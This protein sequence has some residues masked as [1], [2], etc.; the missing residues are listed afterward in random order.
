MV[1]TI[2]AQYA[3]TG[4][5]AGQKGFAASRPSVKPTVWPFAA[6]SASTA[7]S[8]LPPPRPLFAIRLAVVI[9]SNTTSVSPI[10]SGTAGVTV[11]CPRTMPSLTPSSWNSL[12]RAA[13]GP[14]CRPRPCAPVWCCRS[15]PAQCRRPWKP[16]PWSRSP[17]PPSQS[18][19][20]APH[21]CCRRLPVAARSETCSRS[22]SGAWLLQPRC[23][24]CGQET[25]LNDPQCVAHAQLPLAGKGQRRG[26]SL[27]GRSCNAVAQV[28]RAVQAQRSR[29]R[30]IAYEQGGIHGTRHAG[31]ILNIPRMNQRGVP[32]AVFRLQRGGNG[33]V[34]VLHPHH[35]N[36]RHHLFFDDERM[37]LV[38]FAKQKL[39]IRRHRHPGR[40]G[41]HR[42]IL[43]DK[44]L[45]HMRPH[46]TLAV[47]F[48]GESGLRQSFE[49]G[50]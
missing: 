14:Q 33:R 25:W 1:S 7:I 21:R 22:E 37:V 29:R 28:S 13:P 26:H 3:S 24:R 17:R 50:R 48:E 49:I 5:D 38:G 12:A 20:T 18:P 27:A 4:T 32:V 40:R 15:V 6:P 2:N 44:F 11:T 10:N 8:D 23:R 43:A 45:L 46:A 19:P 16:S 47:A 39:C 9:G 42:D 35:R 31:Y 30:G 41:Q 36:E 34:D